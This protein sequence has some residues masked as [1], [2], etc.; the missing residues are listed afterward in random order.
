M[1]MPIGIIYQSTEDGAIFKLTRPGDH[2]TLKINSSVMVTP[3]QPNV[4]WLS[5]ESQ[6]QFGLLP[7]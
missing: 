2:S 7:T 6:F 5:K 3:E 1:I 4:N